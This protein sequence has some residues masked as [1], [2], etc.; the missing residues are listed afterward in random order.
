MGVL[1][2]LGIASGTSPAETKS[3]VRALPSN[4]YT[5]QEMY[6][7]ERR[8]IFSRRWMLITHKSRLP[9]PGDWLKFDIAGYEFIL[10]RSRTGDSING[11]HNVCRHRAFPI[12]QEEKGVAKI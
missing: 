11:F 2:Y 3:P 12:V 8:A 1:N 7:L 6:E 10:C 4:W 9:Q 5:S